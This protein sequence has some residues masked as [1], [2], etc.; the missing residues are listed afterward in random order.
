LDAVNIIIPTGML[1]HGFRVI[2]NT[3]SPVHH[4]TEQ[5][6]WI[7]TTNTRQ[8]ITMKSLKL[9]FASIAIAFTL[10]ACAEKKAEPATIVDQS[11]CSDESRFKEGCQ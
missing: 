5:L 8:R 1:K 11:D 7:K 2:L 9:V 4:C 10:F 6:Y 3:L